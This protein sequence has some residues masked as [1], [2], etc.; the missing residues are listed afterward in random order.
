MSISRDIVGVLKLRFCLSYLYRVRLPLRI[1]CYIASLCYA[2]MLS[3]TPLSLSVFIAYVGYITIYRIFFHPLRSV[4]GPFLARFSK[5]WLVWHVRKGKSHIQFPELHAQF[6]PIVRI[7]PNQVLVC[8]EDAV[9]TVYGAGTSFTKGDWYQMCAAPDKNWKPVD[10]VLDLLTETNMEKYR[11][12]R[13][14]IGPAYSITGLEKHEGLLDAYIDKFVAKLED[15]RGKEVGLANWGHIFALDSMSQFTLGKSPGYTDKGSDDGNEDASHALWQCF[16]VIGLFPGFV[17]LMHSIPK[18]GML[19]VLP[20]SLLLGI[21]IP[22]IW[23]VFNFCSPSI[24]QRLKTLESMK[25]VELPA[26]RP[27]FPQEYGKDVGVPEERGDSIEETDM[28]ATLMRLH[29][30]REARFPPSWVLS[31]ALTNFGAGHDTLMFTLSSA[32][33]HTYT[34][35]SILARL[36]KDMES[37][38]VTRK[39]RYSEIVARVPLLLAVLR[40]S[41]RLWPTIG[42]YLPRL[43]PATGVTLCDTYLPHGTTVGTSLWTSH[44]GSEVF[45]EPHKF[46]PDR[47][48]PDGTEERRRKIGRMDSVWMGFGGGSRS[49]PGQHLARFFVIKALARLVMSC[50]VEVNGEPEIGGW[51]QCTL[52]G[53]GISVKERKM[54]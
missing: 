23:P 17:K 37:Q 43:V 53:V 24:M 6:G 11:R 51:F 16:T 38:G 54:K 12:Q 33:Y 36:R 48:L 14:A 2:S 22:K 4:P 15:L 45:A 1:S 13:R 35:P 29:N 30:D 34:S 18:V 50:D 25:D 32:I 8:E 9:K 49:C 47:W 21:R 39:S 46:D 44:F 28:L 26:S 5:L 20:M 41:M 27:G 40:E 52:T 7:A 42:W 10:E 19:L 3:I 31:I